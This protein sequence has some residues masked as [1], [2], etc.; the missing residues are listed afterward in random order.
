MID[1]LTLID[2]E[3]IKNTW[4]FLM[5]ELLGGI[6]TSIRARFAIAIAINFAQS[7]ESMNAMRDKSQMRLSRRS[8]NGKRDD[9]MRIT[10][11]APR[12]SD[13]RL[14]REESVNSSSDGL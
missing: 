14:S 10:I 4:H 11:N 1:S 12:D 2:L 9:D 5:N 6:H 3:S 13:K 8:L 7:R